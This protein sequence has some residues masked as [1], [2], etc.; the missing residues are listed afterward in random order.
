M[1]G[2]LREV[3][4]REVSWSV[5][6]VWVDVL[7]TLIKGKRL[8]EDGKSWKRGTHALKIGEFPSYVGEG[9]HFQRGKRECEGV[10]Y[11]CDVHTLMWDMDGKEGGAHLMRRG[12]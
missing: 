5:V 7:A 10:K 8:V 4:V 6:G 11:E 9:T 1:S 12:P 2:R 3:S